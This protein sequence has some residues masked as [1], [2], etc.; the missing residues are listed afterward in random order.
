MNTA[1]WKTWLV[2]GLSVGTFLFAAQAANGSP[3]SGGSAVPPRETPQFKAGD[4]LTVATPNTSLMRGEQVTATVPQGQQVVVVEVRDPWVGVYVSIG[5]Q[6]KAGWL[7]ATAFVPRGKQPELVAAG[8]SA[9]QEQ[10]PQV[11]LA[12]QSVSAPQPAAICPVSSADTF[13]R[14]YDAGYYGRHETDPNLE[15]WEPWMYHR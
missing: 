12:A 5:N 11:R 15:T 1:L 7:Q 8:Y 3:D 9:Q 10:G 6:K 2:T 13:F 4:V 14:A